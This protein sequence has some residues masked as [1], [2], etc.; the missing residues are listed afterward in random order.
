[1]IKI[2]D[3]LLYH[4]GYEVDDCTW[5]LEGRVE[6]LGHL[7]AELETEWEMNQSIPKVE[8]AVR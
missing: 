5:L 1:M 4:E 8:L 3:Y 7:E 2:S 6:C